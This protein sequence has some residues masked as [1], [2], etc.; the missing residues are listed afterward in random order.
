MQTRSYTVSCSIPE[1][2]AHIE[3]RPA[4]VSGVS[5]VH[6][7]V[8]L[9]GKM[10]PPPVRIEWED[11]MRD[12]LSVWYPS[13]GVGHALHQWFAPTICRSSFN[14]GAPV[15]CT[16]GDRGLN[17]LTVALSDTVSPAELRFWIKDLEQENR[18]GFSVTLFASES[19]P[20]EEYEADI[21]IDGRRIPYYESVGEV[22]SW[23]CGYGY[24]IPEPPEAAFDPLYSS[25]Y[26]FHQAP[27]ADRLLRELRI[28]A[29]LGFRNVILDDGWQFPGPSVGDYSLC[30]E[31]NPAQDKF[32]DF[33]GFV[34]EVH[35]LGM[36]LILWFTVPFIGVDSPLFDRFKGQ[37]LYIDRGLLQAG[38]LDIRRPRVREFLPGIY[39]CFVAEYDIDGFKFDFIDSFVPGAETVPFNTA[40]GMDCRTVGEAVRTLLAEIGRDLAEIKPGLLFEYRQNYVGPAVNRF[41]NMLRV[42]DCAYDAL[43]NRIGIA[44]IRLMGYP[45]APH[46]DMLFWAP[47]ESVELCAKQLLNILF[48]VPQISVLL[49][50][51]TPEQLSLLRAALAYMNENRDTLLHGQFMPQQPEQNYP[52]IMAEKDGRRI[53]VL[54][55]V[56]SYT[57]DGVA[58]DVHLD[59]AEDGLLL[60]NPGKE[61]L[62]AE[63]FTPFGAEKCD[64]L[65]ISPER[66]VRVPVPRMGFVRIWR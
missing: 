54:H 58:A 65:S 25:W 3:E 59:S 26:N 18:V 29:Q 31:W 1:V 20:V 21:R 51:S 41:G 48:A 45:T 4:D 22:S 46:A 19:D 62:T 63:V 53:V 42:G 50:E 23:W 17:R 33:G 32:A 52:V 5:I 30:G 8:E 61:E 55:G 16:I 56:R 38:V 66:T 15:L 34:R 47:E 35:R 44:D 11:E 40:E 2:S 28:A 6:V 36:K 64:T 27:D 60:E 49:E 13:S 37:Y 12:I 10:V 43:T 24:S 39:H 7:K 14:S 9:P 57:W